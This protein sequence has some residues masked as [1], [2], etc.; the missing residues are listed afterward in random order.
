M[1]IPGRD[2]NDNL[3]AEEC[4]GELVD[5]GRIGA[6]LATPIEAPAGHYA[7]G[8]EGARVVF[9]DGDGD[10]VGETLDEH[11]VGGTRGRAVAELATAVPAP[12]PNG[13]VRQQRAG[14]GNP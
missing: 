9:P 5:Q 10:G 11:R 14:V 12:A 2:G 6:K 7:S 3:Q 1:R 8:H 13:A 4:G